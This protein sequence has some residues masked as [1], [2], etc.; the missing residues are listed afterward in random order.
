MIIFE[1]QLRG[2]EV[3]SGLPIIILAGETE[4]GTVLYVTGEGVM[5]VGPMS[6]V[7]IHWRYDMALGKWQDIDVNGKVVETV[8]EGQRY[9]DLAD[10][11]AGRGP[12]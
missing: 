9:S 10:Y 4:K 12:A 7:L 1:P 6:S 5:K 3:Q 11:T 2:E 8:S